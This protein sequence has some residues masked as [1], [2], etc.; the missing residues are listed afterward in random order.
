MDRNNCI[1]ELLNHLDLELGL[2]KNWLLQQSTE[3]ILDHAYAYSTRENI[4]NSVRE[5]GAIN[6]EQAKALLQYRQPLEEMYKAYEKTG[7]EE[8]LISCIRDLANK[9][10][11]KV[12]EQ[13]KRMPEG[14]EINLR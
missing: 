13:N 6:Q 10:E 8:R 14:L 5:R 7:K 3:E 2:Y 11:R 9:K 12:K 4:I 1:E